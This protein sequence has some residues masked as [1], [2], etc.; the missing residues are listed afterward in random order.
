M[1]FIIKMTYHRFLSI[2]LLASVHA[3]VHA[4]DLTSQIDSLIQTSLPKATIGIA[5]QNLDGSLV[6]TGIG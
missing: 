5:I 4:A 6:Y 2:F 3:S 1:G